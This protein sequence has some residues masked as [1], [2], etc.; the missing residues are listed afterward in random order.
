MIKVLEIDYLEDNFIN[1]KLVSNININ[2]KLIFKKENIYYFGN[3]NEDNLD[4]IRKKILHNKKNI[5]NAIEKGIK[6]IITGNSYELFNNDFKNNSLNLY[7]CYDK[8]I[9]KHK[10]I[11]NIKASTKLKQVNDLNTGIDSQNFKY[12]NMICINDEKNIAKII[13]KVKH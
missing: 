8:N 2:D 10:R 3:Y 5:I 11:K 1:K 12:K 9:F 4:I 6:F 7:T 13:K